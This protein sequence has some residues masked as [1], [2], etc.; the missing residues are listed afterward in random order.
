MI[1]FDTST[2]PI[3]TAL[4][5]RAFEAASK[6]AHANPA[7][8]PDALADPN[9]AAALLLDY[10]AGYTASRLCASYNL[11]L[12]QL[13]AWQR[14]PETQ[15]LLR[16]HTQ[17]AADQ[18]RHIQHAK[19][20]EILLT[21]CAIA[22]RGTSEP[23]CRRAASDLLRAFKYRDELASREKH[24]SMRS[25]PNPPAA[26]SGPTKSDPTSSDPAE[27][28]TLSNPPA[29][30]ESAPLSAARGETEEVESTHSEPLPSNQRP[31]PART[32]A[33]I[34]PAHLISPEAS[35][36]APQV[37]QALPPL[38]Q[39]ARFMPLPSPDFN[40]F[41]NEDAIFTHAFPGRTDKHTLRQAILSHQDSLVRRGSEALL[42][43]NL[44]TP[45]DESPQ[46]RTAALDF[47]TRFARAHP[48]P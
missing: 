6:P 1:A 36:P 39:L 31:D 15:E 28:T 24:R 8:N 23:E 27:P 5:P 9:L 2:S 25:K 40:P 38:D 10:L 32:E 18:A 21:L 7:P 30:A 14:L 44:L 34:P 47:Y 43:H 42:N 35:I 26:E 29:P 33:E 46:A 13:L 4:L 3:S 45:A 41:W 19:E 37:H 17:F 11:T 16:Q 22:T 48:P 20:P 12:P